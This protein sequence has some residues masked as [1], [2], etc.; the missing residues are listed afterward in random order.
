MGLAARCSIHS[1]LCG[2]PVE[3]VS[4]VSGALL[5]VEVALLELAVVVSV[6]A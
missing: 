5:D 1:G 4:S 2:I 6:V 3:V